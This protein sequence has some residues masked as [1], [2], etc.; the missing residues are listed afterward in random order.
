MTDSLLIF[1]Q[2]P[3][4]N[5]LR[6]VLREIFESRLGL[7]FQITSSKEDA[8]TWAGPLIIYGEHSDL[9]GFHIPS[10]GLLNSRKRELKLPEMGKFGDLP[11]LYPISLSHKLQ[12]LDFDLF[13]S[14]FYVLSRMEEYNQASHD[15]LGRFSY[16][17]SHLFQWGYL[18]RP[19][20]DWW[21]QQFYSKL[22]G[23]YPGI[24]AHFPSFK[25]TPTFD[26]D[27]AYA[28]SNKS[29][30]RTLKGLFLDLAEG[31]WD[32]LAERKRV[33][34]GTQKDPFDTYDEILKYHAVKPL[35]FILIGSYGGSDNALNYFN[36]G[37]ISLVKALAD[38]TIVGIHPS[39]L[40]HTR[41]ELFIRECDILSDMLHRPLTHS[42]Q[43]FLK[44]TWP[45]SY[46]R[47]V[48]QEILHD[49]SLGY[50][51]KPGFRAGTCHPF[52]FYD[53]EYEQET[54]LMIHSTIVMDKALR[55]SGNERKEEATLQFKQL[56]NECKKVNGEFITLWHNNTYA[57]HGAWAGWKSVYLKCLQMAQL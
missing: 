4:S 5:R 12:G 26:I 2:F 36:P 51:D 52:R 10:S 1:C 25:F 46:Q 57:D 7:S 17:S 43:H 23:C 14:V 18:D 19:L 44:I 47:L 30:I 35:F 42:R 48:R 32:L 21:I 22:K 34:M 28:Y 45:E 6:Y 31:K 49:Y 39:L 9:H 37:F 20:L 50:P 41:P 33:L 8:L 56:L 15:D 3:G 24:S 38:E 16:T 54:K 29:I 53:L 13:A 11:I 40:S 27:L 55:I